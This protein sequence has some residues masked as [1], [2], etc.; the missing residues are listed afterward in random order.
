MHPIVFLHR[1]S[2]IRQMHPRTSFLDLHSLKVATLEVT[3][4]SE[5]DTNR[6]KRIGQEIR[7]HRQANL[8]LAS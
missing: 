1:S 5:T 4:P 8:R 2:S 3:P 7:I 6:L